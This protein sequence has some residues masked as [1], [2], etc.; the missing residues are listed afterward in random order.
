M[1]FHPAI[2]SMIDAARA[3]GR[4]DYADCTPQQAREMSA[5]RRAAYGMGPGVAAVEDVG[6]PTRAGTIA[7]RL[8]RPFGDAAG[9]VVYLHGGG[10]V[11][12]TLD[13]YE[14]VARAL[15]A[16]S[17]CAVLL[18]DYRLAPEHPFPAG[19]HDAQDALHWAWRHRAELGFESLP[20]VVAGDSAG[21]NLAAACALALKDDITIALQL[22]FYP[23]TDS[24]LDNACYRRYGED[25]LLSRRS[26]GW[27]F[28]HYA[29]GHPRDDPRISPLREPDLRGVPPAWI[30]TAEFDVL[31][32]EAEAYAARLREAAVDVEA[33]RYAGLAH[34]FARMI[35]LVDDAAAAVKE[36]GAAIELACRDRRMLSPGIDQTKEAP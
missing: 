12:G 6:I 2:R 24:D 14:I 35:N 26:M 18:V 17:G 7:G 11:L 15:A 36:A 29:A 19:L 13:D 30:A 3:A 23:V 28:D 4:P 34:G 22:L 25:Y 20:L 21:G 16:G 27:F 8:F 1:P 32:D 10:W 9:L 31:R 5:S 33:R